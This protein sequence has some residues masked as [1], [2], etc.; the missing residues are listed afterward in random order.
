MHNRLKHIRKQFGLSQA[1]MASILEVTQSSYSKT[2]KGETGVT[3]QHVIQL[4]EKLNIN[5]NYLLLG[6]GNM[7]FTNSLIEVDMSQANILLPASS[8][9]DY[10]RNWP[11]LPKDSEI[12]QIPGIEAPAMTF[13]VTG[14]SMEP[15]LVKGDWITCR[16]ASIDQ[17]DERSIYVVI[18]KDDIFISHIDIDR[19]QLILTPANSIYNSTRIDLAD[20]HETWQAITRITHHIGGANYGMSLIEKVGKIEQFL[21]ENFAQYKPR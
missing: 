18:G 12:I 8:Y 4:F 2:E 1:E 21:M 5:P 9:S 7:R 20:V 13:E 6:K 19:N 16:K 14:D 3:T 10:I 17:V 11:N 15:F